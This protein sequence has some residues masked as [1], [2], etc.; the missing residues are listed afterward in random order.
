MASNMVASGS[1][2]QILQPLF[3]RMEAIFSDIGFTSRL[4]LP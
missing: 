2:D 1:I 3:F 4:S